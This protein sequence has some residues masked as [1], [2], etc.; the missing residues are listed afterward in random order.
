M[1]FSF[2]DLF[3]FM[4]IGWQIQRYVCTGGLTNEKSARREC[5]VGRAGAFPVDGVLLAAL[6]IVTLRT[7]RN[8]QTA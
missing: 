5:S 1:G 3:Y 2:L 4:S 6:W 7:V 8:P